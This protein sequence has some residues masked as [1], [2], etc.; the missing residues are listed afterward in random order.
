MTLDNTDQLDL[1]RVLNLKFV[2][3]AE[4]EDYEEW[5]V[6]VAVR[7]LEHGDKIGVKQGQGYLWLGTPLTTAL[8]FRELILLSKI[9]NV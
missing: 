4:R 5:E 6:E 3:E 2:T 9:S 1:K 8:V 7:L